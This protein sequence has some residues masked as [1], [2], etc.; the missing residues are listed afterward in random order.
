MFRVFDKKKNKFL[1]DCYIDSKG[2]IHQRDG[3]LDT[4]FELK[5]CELDFNL[6]IMDMQLTQI[7]ENDIILSGSTKYIVKR[8]SYGIVVESQTQSRMPITQLTHRFKIIG[9]IHQNPELLNA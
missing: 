1:K 8:V 4:L 9:N 7:Y 5:N 2:N 6:G 3:L